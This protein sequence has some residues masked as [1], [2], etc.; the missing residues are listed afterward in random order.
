MTSITFENATISELIKRVERITPK[1]GEAF[2]KASGVVFDI[3]PGEAWPVVVRATNLEIY[4]TEWVNAIAVE[5]DPAR[6]R[7]PSFTLASIVTK[8]PIG[9]GK[10]VT[11]TT[12]GGKLSISSGRFKAKIGM[13]STEF[14]P[15]WTPFDPT[16]TSP[17]PNL[18]ARIQQVAWATAKGAAGEAMSGVRFNGETLAA[19]DRYRMASVPMPIEGLQGDLVVP[20]APIAPLLKQMGD[21]NVGILPNGMLALMPNEYTQIVA[22]IYESKFPPVERVM[23]RDYAHHI[24]INRDAVVEIINR[25]GVA[26][27]KNRMPEMQVFIGNEEM[28][29]FVKETDGDGFAGDVYEIAG[30]ASHERFS[31]RITPAN[32]VDCL[33]ASPNSSLELHY[34]PS[35]PMR[36]LRVDGGSGFEA[37]LAPRSGYE[38]IGEQ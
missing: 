11:F 23:Q 35:N 20:L 19:T 18:G 32:L 5:G 10:T 37:W 26:D 13:I 25:V 36:L 1:K 9:T 34:D 14:Y 8:L 21:T 3:T 4:Y 30:Q 7:L 33:A 27:A 24:K 38:K 12:D 22:T 29:F 15:Q 28:A 6:W 31:F 2:D 17:V 16:A